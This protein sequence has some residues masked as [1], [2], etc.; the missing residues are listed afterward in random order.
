MRVS[1]CRPVH[2]FTLRQRNPFD[3]H[4]YFDDD[5]S[6]EL[7]LTL[8]QRMMSKFPWMRFY[9]VHDR[10]IGPHPAPMWEADFAEFGNVHRWDEVLAWLAHEH[11]TLSVLVH[12]HSTDGSWADHTRH[13]TW[14]GEPLSLRLRPAA[15]PQPAVSASVS[16]RAADTRSGTAQ[17]SDA[18]ERPLDAALWA[19]A[20]ARDPMTTLELRLQAA[21]AS[22]Q[23]TE[24]RSA[25]DAAEQARVSQRS[26]HL[27]KARA[28]LA[29]LA[30]DEPPSS[31]P[32]SSPPPSS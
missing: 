32:P 14:L 4:V 8:R 5:A 1:A 31:P 21:V 11:G 17:M 28:L 29:T 25:I 24:L 9:R 30:P 10:C 2:P 12:P 19:R 13:A 7:A 27:R 16:R 15:A 20:N 18:S 22:G 26:P 6:R 3:V 23:L